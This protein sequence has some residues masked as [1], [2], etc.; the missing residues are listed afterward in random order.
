MGLMTVEVATFYFMIINHIY[1]P[2]HLFYSHKIL[3][4]KEYLIIEGK[5]KL[6]LVPLVMGHGVIGYGAQPVFIV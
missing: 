6:R 2:N 4:K 3:W 1:K 5:N